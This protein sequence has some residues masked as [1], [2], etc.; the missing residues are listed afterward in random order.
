MC[1]V[2]RSTLLHDNS[3]AHWSALFRA[4]LEEQRI[5]LAYCDSWLNPYTKSCLRGLPVYKQLHVY[6]K[7]VR[8]RIL[9][10]SQRLEKCVE[11]HGGYFE[12]LT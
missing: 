10:W 12:G 6:P 1:G 4:Y 5:G 3:S 11:Y 8:K 7:T 2:R 9:E